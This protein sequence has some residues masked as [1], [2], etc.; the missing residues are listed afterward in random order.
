MSENSKILIADD[1]V[2]M[3]KVVIETLKSAGYTTFIEA[4]NGKQAIELFH[5]EKPSLI[6]LDVIMP[7]MDGLEVM[8]NIGTEANIIM[9]SA[10]GQ[11]GIIEE[12]L[13][14]G[15]KG[16]LVKPFDKDKLV[17]EVKKVLG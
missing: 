6:L 10:I 7:E 1:S 14:L 8:K 2:F 13:G 4:E 9:V 17:L 15:A 12:A 11:E 5:S 16:F 3:R